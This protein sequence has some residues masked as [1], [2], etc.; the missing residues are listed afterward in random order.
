MVAACVEED[1]ADACVVTSPREL[2]VP[3]KR[4]SGTR[5]N[6]ATLISRMGSRQS[7]AAKGELKRG[8]QQM[9]VPDYCELRYQDIGGDELER[10]RERELSLIHI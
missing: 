2:H 1:T 6:L 5:V 7:R 8:L 3:L 4:G 10:E 9:L